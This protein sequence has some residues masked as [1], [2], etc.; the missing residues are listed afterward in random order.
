MDNGSSNNDIR[1][2]YG[3][4]ELLALQHESLDRIERKVDEGAVRQAEAIA[5]IDTR[6]TILEQAPRDHEDRIR[7]LEGVRFQMRGVYLA[8][9]FMVTTLATMSWHIWG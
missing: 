2:S 4:K 3:V 7:S 1:I 5:K 9:A 8:L 6:V